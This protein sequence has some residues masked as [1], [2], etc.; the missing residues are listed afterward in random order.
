MNVE[1]LLVTPGQPVTPNGPRGIASEGEESNFNQMLASRLTGVAEQIDQTTAPFNAGPDMKG[2]AWLAEILNR[3]GRSGATR[4]Y[5]TDQNL[6]PDPDGEASSQVPNAFLSISLTE[7]LTALQAAVSQGSV[8]DGL[9]E[10]VDNVVPNVEETDDQDQADPTTLNSALALLSA[11]VLRPDSPPLGPGQQAGPAANLNSSPGI[12]DTTIAQTA[13]TTPVDTGDV[14]TAD[15]MADNGS[16]MLASLDDG[17]PLPLSSPVSPLEASAAPEVNAQLTATFEH[18][19]SALTRDDAPNPRTVNTARVV[20][21]SPVQLKAT[22]DTMQVGEPTPVVPPSAPIATTDI[23]SVA[24]VNTVK[25]APELPNIPALHQIVDAVGLI[26]WDGE[27][28]VRMHLHPDSLG[29]LLIQVN[30]T[31]GDVSLRMLAETPQ[32]HALIQ[33]H[34]PQ[35]KESLVAQGMEVSGMSVAVGGDPSAFSAPGRRP[36]ERP[37]AVTHQATAAAPD[38]VDRQVSNQPAVRAWGDLRMVDYH[39]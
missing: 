35:L 11:I 21:E 8:T 29:E 28:E 2:A 12:V 13:I 9:S 34:L 1:T 36:Y 15:N 33:E 31:K 3:L 7:I 4:Q 10:Q 17:Q 26:R 37:G 38:D 32:T 6:T 24:E 39:V 19:L 25:A 22:A 16:Q 30:V 20:A 27:T 18:T 14:P 5:F 23:L